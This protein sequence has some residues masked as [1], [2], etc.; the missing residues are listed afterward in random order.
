MDFVSALRM[1]PLG[2]LVY[3]T[4]KGFPRLVANRRHAQMVLCA[5]P[6]RL[7][8]KS[9]GYQVC[10]PV[11]ELMPPVL[12]FPI[13]VTHRLPSNNYWLEHDHEGGC[14]IVSFR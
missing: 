10:V 5:I 6:M 1:I 4:W 12:D 13:P 8:D 3:V 14:R 2:V 11:K 9:D 7:A